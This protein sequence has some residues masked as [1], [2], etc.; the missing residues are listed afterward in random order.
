MESSQ[1]KNVTFN[2]LVNVIEAGFWGFGSGMASASAFL[3]L[4][5]LKFTDSALLIGLIPAIQTIGFQLPQ[6]FLA[7]KIASQAHIKPLVMKMTIH[8]RLPFLG[9]AL[10][11]LFSDKLPSIAVI[12]LVYMMLIWQGIGGGFTGNAWQNMVCKMIPSDM[13]SMFFSIQGAGVNFLSSIGAFITGIILEKQPGSFGFFLAFLGAFIS[14]IVSYAILNMAREEESVEILDIDNSPHILKMAAKILKKDTSFRWFVISRFLL[15][16]GNMASGFYIIYIKNNFN[17]DEKTIGLLASTQF[18]STVVSGLLLGWLS[19]HVGRKMAMQVSLVV[20]VL[21][22][23][24]AYFAPSL[25]FFFII[26]AL[27]GVINGA[28][29]SVFLSFTLEFG[30]N[31]ERP[32]YVGLINTLIA[33]STL[34]AQ[35]FGGWIADNLSFN[36]TFILA[37]SFGIVAFLITLFFVKEPN[38]KVPSLA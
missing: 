32:T 6:L 10:V 15:P 35:L 14:M 28:F 24:L 4:F 31:V 33:P 36:V 9:L 17:A 21:S 13:R 20:V 5:L 29:W 23:I 22:P 12:V 27:T 25:S 11:A 8:E 2:Y 19:D 30:T 16:F 1:P 18:I 37:A 34:I 7:K 26:Y 38:P 3:P